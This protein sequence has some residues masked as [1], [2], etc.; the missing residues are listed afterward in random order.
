[1]KKLLVL[2]I[3]LILVTSCSKTKDKSKTIKVGA[4]ITPHAEIL[5]EAKKALQEK[6]FSLEVVEFNDYVQPNISLNDGSLDANYFQHSPYLEDFNQQ[7]NW[8]LT[9]AGKIHYEPFGLYGGK[10]KDIQ[11]VKEGAVIAVP[12]DGTNEGRA[13][14]LLQDLGLITLKEGTSFSATILDI[15]SNP[16]NLVIKELEAAQLPKSLADVDFAIING[17]Y[18]LEA[19]L[20]IKDDALAI[21]DASSAAA[22]TYGN[23]IAVRKEDVESE[24]IKAL[25]EVL[26]SEAIKDWINNKYQGAVVPSK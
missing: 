8:D 21:E 14:F 3:A 20:S 25:V 15:E 19:G 12:N 13:L 22:E 2:F 23:I 7:R 4:S 24:K 17:N 5:N 9:S 11:N 18:A 1:M 6:G 10:S 26:K 16:K